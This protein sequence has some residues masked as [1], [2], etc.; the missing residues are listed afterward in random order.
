MVAAMMFPLILDSVR[1]AAADSLWKRRN[2][3]IVEFLAGYL[4]PWLALGVA[5]GLFQKSWVR[6]DWAAALL[7]GIA[8]LWQRTRF[9]QQALIACCQTVPLAPQGWRADFDCLRFGAVIGA[10]SW[11]RVGP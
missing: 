8:A 3:A 11:R 10:A 1:T 9:H 4:G 6:T 5:A 2:R 7:F